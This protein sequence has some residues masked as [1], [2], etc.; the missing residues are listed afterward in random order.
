MH[1]A[2]DDYL[3]KGNRLMI[4]VLWLHAMLCLA[5]A[6]VHGTWLSAL[7][8]GLPAAAIPTFLLSNAPEA[9]ASRV[10]VGLAFMVLSALAI[11]QMHGMMEMHFGVFILLALL[12]Y[13]RDGVTLYAASGLILVHHLL[14]SSLQTEGS[15]IYLFETTPGMGRVAVHMGYIIFET[16]L[17]VYLCQLM[18]RR[19]DEAREVMNV[20]RRVNQDDQ[21]LDLSV[22]GDATRGDTVVQLNNLLSGLETGISQAHDA[23]RALAESALTLQKMADEA[24][25]M[26]EHQSHSSGDLVQASTSLDSVIQ[27][28][29][30]EA[31]AAAEQANAAIQ[32]T[33]D[34]NRILTDAV[35]SMDVLN[36]QV[37]AANKTIAN[38]HAES[39]Q[40]GTVL[41]VIK[42]IADQTNLLALNAAIEAARA[43]EQGRGFAVVADE[44]R[45]LASRTQ[46]STQEIQNMI[47]RLRAGVDSAVSAIGASG[48]EVNK[49]VAHVRTANDAL[50]AIGEQVHRIAQTN[51]QIEQTMNQQHELMQKLA[52]MASSMAK[53]SEKARNV[54]GSTAGVGVRIRELSGRLT[55][56]FGRFKVG[57]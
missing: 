42:N 23:T 14:F 26:A 2:V 36:S 8:I 5:L 30:R 47:S 21:V 16:A 13:Y 45:T 32:A 54:A 6:S 43:G 20:S 29:S 55:D 40:I 35:H 39:E 9:R 1:I 37:N 25:E 22:R 56:A 48:A 34:G 18:L 46:S 28:V 44:V 41:G 50:N 38:L 3:L 31:T 33:N 7:L 52:Q 27:S 10:A 51:R 57:N 53:T 49:G 19:G 11:Q 12:M 24:V 17:L 15:G 4:T